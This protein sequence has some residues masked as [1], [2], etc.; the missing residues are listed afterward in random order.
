M[1]QQDWRDALS[2]LAGQF[3]G[4]DAVDAATSVSEQTSESDSRQTSAIHIALERKGRG[5][6][7]ATIIFGFTIDDDSLKQLAAEIKRS[8]GC[9]GSARGGEILIQGDRVDDCKKFLSDRGFKSVF[10]KKS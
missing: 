5:G 1:Q 8:L 3:S 2:N 6:K 4:D 10:D 7:T 9:G